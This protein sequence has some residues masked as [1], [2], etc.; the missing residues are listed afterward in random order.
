MNQQTRGNWRRQWLLS[1]V[2]AMVAG[3]WGGPARAETLTQEES[4][5][6]GKPQVVIANDLYRLTF[7]PA[8]GGRCVSLKI[9]A[10]DREWMADGKTV[11]LFLDHFAHQYWPGELLES[12]YEYRVD[13]VPGSHLRR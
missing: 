7:E 6:D 10:T 13:R 5:V 4:Q 8:R 2:A 3:F 11:G 1:V 12:A 9:K